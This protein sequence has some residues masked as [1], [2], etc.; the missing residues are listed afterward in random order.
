MS[1]GVAAAAVSDIVVV[2][3]GTTGVGVTES[4]GVI[5]NGIAT[6][7]YSEDMFVIIVALTIGGRAVI[8]SGSADVSSWATVAAV[9]AGNGT[10]P[11]ATI[12]I[13]TKT[14][15]LYRLQCFTDT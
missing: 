2:G 7:D 3:A 10:G 13:N 1:T 12:S 5:G 8:S 11:V 6:T 15:R 14:S 9:I 4:D